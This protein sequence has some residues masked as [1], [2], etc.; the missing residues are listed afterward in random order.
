M[1]GGGRKLHKYAAKS[2]TNKANDITLS[3]H[4]ISNSFRTR[5]VSFVIDLLDLGA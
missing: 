2:N 3:F 1:R 5:R 4:Q